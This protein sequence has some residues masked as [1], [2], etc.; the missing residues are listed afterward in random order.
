MLSLSDQPFFYKDLSPGDLIWS[1]GD[2]YYAMCISVERTSE[3]TTAW[4]IYNGNIKR[5][6]RVNEHQSKRLFIVT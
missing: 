5:V 3:L 2:D 1:D 6:V 4:F